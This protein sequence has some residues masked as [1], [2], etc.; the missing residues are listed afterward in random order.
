MAKFDFFQ[1]QKK[2]IWENS[3]KKLH[4]KNLRRNSKIER[5][6]I[7]YARARAITQ[8]WQFLRNN[9]Y[10]NPHKTARFEN[11]KKQKKYIWENSYKRLHAENLSRD[12]LGV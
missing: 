11:F 10:L 2:Y 7:S 9:I 8:N 5:V 4:A 12:P 3:Y 6:S 1:K